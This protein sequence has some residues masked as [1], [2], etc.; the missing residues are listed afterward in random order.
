ME[1]NRKNGDAGAGDSFR[2]RTHA[3][4]VAPMMA[5]TDRHCRAFHRSLAP[6]ARLYAEMATTG[7]VLHGGAERVLAF[8]ERERPLAAQFGGAE[9]G[10][11]ARCAA[12]A[13]ER[14][15][16]EVNLN[17]GCPSSRVQRGAFG[18]CLMLRPKRVAACVAAMR[19]AA[20]VPVTV[21]CRLGVD[22]HADYG[23][24]RDFVGHCASAGA[25][26]V[27]VHARI[28]V[29]AGLT[30]AQN[31]SAPPLDYQRVRRLKRE[32]PFLRVVLNGGLTTT[33]QV[34]D[35]LQWA[36]GVMIG[37]AAYRNPYWLAE[38]EHRLFGTALPN[39]PH[40]ALARHLDYVEHALRAGARLHDVTR[41]MLGLFQG[42]PGARAFRRQIATAGRVPGAGPETLQAAAELVAQ[43]A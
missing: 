34:H 10:D 11:L 23:F 40:E 26:T 24:L 16:D 42:V 43:A 33:A 32:L 17:V 3:L 15:F 19:D 37:R 39:G 35:A 5:W 21:K 27:I 22:D 2:R 7:A 41:H 4:C 38:V 31:R 20:P 29:L 13:A 30:P 8:D 1:K 9:P 36:D 18:A 12:L 6:H 14:G 25:G 28:A